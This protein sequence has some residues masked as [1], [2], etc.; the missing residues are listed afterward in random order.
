[1]LFPPLP[2]LPPDITLIEHIPRDHGVDQWLYRSAE[3]ACSVVVFYQSEGGIC[4]LWSL[5]CAG[6]ENNA[7][8]PFDEDTPNL[9]G[10]CIGDESFSIFALRWDVKITADAASDV[11]TQFWISREV[12]WGG[13]VPPLAPQP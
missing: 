3:A 8:V 13:E 11:R 1:M 6:V 7:A 4:S 9:M 5:D 12:S 10:R 2:P